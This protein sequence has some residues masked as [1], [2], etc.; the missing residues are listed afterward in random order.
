VINH[1]VINHPALPTYLVISL[2]TI[3]I[4]DPIIPPATIMVASNALNL[5]LNS[6]FSVDICYCI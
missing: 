4:P 6:E 3:K 1:A 2:L 5:G